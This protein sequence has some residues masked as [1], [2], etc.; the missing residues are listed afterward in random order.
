[1]LIYGMWKINSQVWP[2]LENS[3]ETV[4]EFYKRILKVL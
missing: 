3:K 4:I 1:M 2:A